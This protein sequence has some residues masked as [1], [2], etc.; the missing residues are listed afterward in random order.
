M[1]RKLEI[2]LKE[3]QNESVHLD[4]LSHD[5][6]NSFIRVVESLK[7]IISIYSIENNEVKYS[8]FEGS[9]GIAAHGN[10]NLFDIIHHDI[11]IAIN[12]HCENPDFT[13]HL[14]NIQTEIKKNNFDYYFYYNDLDKSKKHSIHNKL[15]DASQIRTKRK[16][17]TIGYQLK[18]ISGLIN[19][20]GGKKP[21]YHFD[22]GSGI[23]KTISCS[24][25]DALETKQFL[26]ESVDS[27][28]LIKMPEDEDQKEHIIH[29]TILSKTISSELKNFI[30]FYEKEEDLIEKLTTIHDFVDNVFLKKENAHEILKTL[31]IIFNDLNFKLSEIKTLLVI[32]KPFKNHE[33]IKEVRENLINTY[34]MKIN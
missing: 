16:N 1:N 26:Y 3:S 23:R 21:N 13:K 18:V 2:S 28:V 19:Q 27:V 15:K 31:L 17:N 24:K 11:D 29:K 30:S 10:E 33:L 34:N 5:A 12:G 25:E 6:I 4:N 9:A 32:S 7:S 20:I 8:F 14:R 22:Y